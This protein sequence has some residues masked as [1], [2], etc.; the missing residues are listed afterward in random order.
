MSSWSFFHSLKQYGR[1]LHGAYERILYPHIFSGSLT[2]TQASAWISDA[3][4]HQ[5]PV[6]VGRLGS[7][8]SR[9]LGEAL[10]SYGRFSRV[11]LKEAHRNA[12]LFPVDQDSLTQAAARIHNG[13][14]SVDLLALWQS[15]YQAK[16]VSRLSVLPP[17]CSLASLEPWWQ[18]TPWTASLYGKRVLVIHPFVETIRSQ[19]SKRHLLFP[20]RSVL[21][22][23]D[24]QLLQP[25]IT[26]AG[27]T[28]GYSSWSSALDE[29]IARTRACSFDIALIGCGA[30]GLP[31]AHAV[32]SMGLPAIHLGGSL[33]LLFGIRGR[34]WESMSAYFKLMN[35]SWV[36]PRPSEIP[37][38]SRS[39]DGGC[40]W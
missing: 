24:L 31:L 40:Y 2:E 34:R 32:K 12:G 4:T 7:V 13:L 1:R 28:Q 9:L 5:Y 23:F 33:Q 6:L 18:P 27:A 14:T 17:R 16:V 25:P 15:P 21:P 3:I 10:F 20:G 39:V 26:L 37:A 11:T 29:L 22:D 8:E 30:Y 19:W 35:E 38:A 36:R